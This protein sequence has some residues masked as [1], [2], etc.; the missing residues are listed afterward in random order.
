M[1]V[2]RTGGMH[3]QVTLGLH[4][5][6]GMRGVLGGRDQFRGD[7]TYHRL[8]RRWNGEV[9]VGQSADNVVAKV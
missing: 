8:A 2:G 9:P 5:R 6:A 4:P 7:R 3:E 1:R